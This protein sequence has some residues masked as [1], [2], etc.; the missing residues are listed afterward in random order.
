MA[1][2][3]ERSRLQHLGDIEVEAVVELGRMR[4]SLGRVRRL[5]VG[6]VLVTDRLAGERMT[7]RINGVPFAEGE[8]VVVN[9]AMACRVTGMVPLPA[10][11]PPP[12]AGAQGG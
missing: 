2:D 10:A 12:T 5:R 6:D 9:R 7:L 8:T 4:L 1:T 11:A 3:N